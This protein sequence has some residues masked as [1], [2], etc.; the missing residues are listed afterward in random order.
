[1]LTNDGKGIVGS[2]VN[3]QSHLTTARLRRLP[4]RRTRRP[5]RRGCLYTITSFHTAV[6][7]SRRMTR[8]PAR[9]IPLIATPVFALAHIPSRALTDCTACT[10]VCCSPHATTCGKVFPFPWPFLLA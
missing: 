3:N 7:T 1:M 2:C 5:A 9:Q 10:A 4:T 8:A 6:S